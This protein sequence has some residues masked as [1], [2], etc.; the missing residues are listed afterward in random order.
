MN[1]VMWV[2]RGNN[3]LRTEE[4]VIGFDVELLEQTSNPI[5]KLDKDL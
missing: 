5:T 1:S 3:D 4:M 2:K